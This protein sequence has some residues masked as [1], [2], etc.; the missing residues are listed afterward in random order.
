MQ[1][2][3]CLPEAAFTALTVALTKDSELSVTFTSVRESGGQRCQAAAL[4]KK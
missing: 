1:E 4:L 2:A 3:E